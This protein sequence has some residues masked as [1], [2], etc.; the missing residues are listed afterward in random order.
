MKKKKFSRKNKDK[1]V[2]TIIEIRKEMLQIL[3]NLSENLDRELFTSTQRNTIKAEI[4]EIAEMIR[5]KDKLMKRVENLGPISR[6]ERVI[7]N[8]LLEQTRKNV[9]SLL[10]KKRK[11]IV[12]TQYDLEELE[13]VDNELTDAEKLIFEKDRIVNKVINRN[14]EDEKENVHI[15]K[16]FNIPEE[17]PKINPHLQRYFKVDKELTL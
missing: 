1:K 9:I 14:H 11:S 4:R 6:S 8:N 12:A 7:D 13:I 2:N 5:D 3:H 10:H 15:R 17:E 16:Y